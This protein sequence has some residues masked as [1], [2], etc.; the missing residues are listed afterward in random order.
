M[1]NNNYY[2]MMIVGIY[3]IFIQMNESCILIA[4]I[5]YICIYLYGSKIPICKS[6]R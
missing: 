5:Y 4:I 3:L 6:L 2:D 1:W